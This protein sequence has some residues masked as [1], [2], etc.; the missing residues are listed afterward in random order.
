V[1]KRDAESN[2]LFAANATIHAT[3]PAGLPVL[4]GTF[5]LET[6]RRALVRTE[7]GAVLKV[8]PGDRIGTRRVMAIAVD[9][10]YLKEP[11]QMR[12]LFIPGTFE[13]S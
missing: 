2:P 5:G 9:R 6:D 12:A 7:D 10:L 8:A 3:W 4:L 11:G 1:G 13:P